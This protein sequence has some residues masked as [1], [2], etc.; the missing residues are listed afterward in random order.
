MFQGSALRATAWEF[1]GLGLLVAFYVLGDWLFGMDV[2]VLNIVGPMWLMAVLGM[3]AVRMI[4]LD[5]GVVWTALFW[6]RVSSSVYFGLGSLF[7]VASNDATVAYM[8]AFF[9]YYG[10]DVFKVN[11]ITAAAII[12]VLAG[13]NALLVLVGLDRGERQPATPPA[14][15]EGKALLK[16]GLF[17]LVTGGIVKYL[18]LVPQMLNLSNFTLPGSIGLIANFTYIAV[19][20]L[21]AWSLEHKR[22]AFPF[23]AGW[24]C[25]EMLIGIL[26]FNKTEVLLVLMMFLFAFLRRRV[27]LMRLG[28][29]AAGVVL[30]FLSIIPLVDYGRVQI[31][32]RYTCAGGMVDLSERLDILLSKLSDDAPVA[33]S[34]VS[35]AQVRISYTNQAVFAV[36]RRD[37]GFAGDTLSNALAIFVPRFLW[38]EKPSLTE[39]AMEFNYGAT[40]NSASASSPGLFAEAY[41]DFGWLGLV[42]LMIPLGL[43]LAFISC[44]AIV[45]V[46]RGQ[47]LYFPVVLLGVRIGFRTDGYFVPDVAGPMMMMVGLYIVLSLLNRFMPII[48]QQPVVTGG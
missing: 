23:V 4:L 39:M 47:W 34:E 9:A 13:A 6:F 31:C 7:A 20:L 41:W 21:T 32:L 46:N 44:R 48:F 37:S 10:E 45:V 24:V 1:V 26:E 43:I 11:L 27:T 22:T 36:R 40:G 18:F 12:S 38:P 15:S 19:F 28:M 29:V 17:F 35:G 2:T 14:I 33:D 8:Q 30:C 42:L 3:G 16:T 25:L 5:A